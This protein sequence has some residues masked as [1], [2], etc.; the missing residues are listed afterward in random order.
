[1][2]V[3]ILGGYGAF[4]GRL[5]PPRRRRMGRALG[6]VGNLGLLQTELGA[7]MAP[8]AALCETVTALVRLP[9]RR[10]P[11]QGAR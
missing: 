1:M 8:L 7:L 3:L 9:T 2:R 6:G 5:G 4:G 11:L 10:R